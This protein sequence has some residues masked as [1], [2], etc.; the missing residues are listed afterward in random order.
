MEEVA[1]R[2]VK[3]GVTGWQKCVR[4]ARRRA[5]SLLLQAKKK[6]PKGGQTSFSAKD[7]CGYDM[8]DVGRPQS[9]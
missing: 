4:K 6:P 9:D 8:S 3:S 5:V 1:V 2:V 7:E